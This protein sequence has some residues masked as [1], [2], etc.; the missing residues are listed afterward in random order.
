MY[1]DAH[2]LDVLDYSYR[3]TLRK[4][5]AL[6]RGTNFDLED[7]V[8]GHDRRS[9][10]A[11]SFARCDE[12]QTTAIDEDSKDLDSNFRGKFSQIADDGRIVVVRSQLGKFSSIV[13]TH[14]SIR[15]WGYQNSSPQAKVGDVT[16]FW[17]SSVANRNS[18]EEMINTC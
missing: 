17:A 18:G 4:Q 12:F 13:A 11:Y 14:D 9:F 7:T 6:K 3:K 8:L 10:V 1:C 15:L 5:W 16:N 2:V